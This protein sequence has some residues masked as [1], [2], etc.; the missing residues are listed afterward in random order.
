MKSV[1]IT[2]RV[3][4]PLSLCSRVWQHAQRS[5]RAASSMAEERS[6]FYRTVWEA[7]AAAVGATVTHMDGSL[8]EICCGELRLRVRDNVTSLD[9]PVTLEMAGKKPL[10]YRMLAE[11]QIPV[12]RHCVC[13]RDDVETAR[14][15]VAAAG[16]PCVI[17]PAYASSAGVGITTGV[18]DGQLLPLT[19]AWAGASSRDI[20]VEEQIGGE[21]Y[22]LLYLDGELVDA[23]L[24]RPPMVH[25]DGHST[26]RQLIAAEN[27]D[28]A[29]MGA[30]AAQSLIRV[31]H[32]LKFTLGRQGYHV[33][34]ILSP[35][36]VVP[37]KTVVND[38]RREENEAAS[39]RICPSIVEAGSAAAEALGV[40][41][42]GV[43]VITNDPGVPLSE[44]GA[45]VLEVNT[46]PGYYYHYMRK[47]G[48]AAVA[49]TI[50]QRL[51]GQSPSAP[52]DRAGGALD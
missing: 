35:G 47:G 9:D 25:G 13:R 10:V 17:K 12:P 28:R 16:G 30:E 48:G 41:L 42:A 51:T 31:D 24:R 40:R 37:V 23:V 52:S 33:G 8:L 43:D 36:A 11:R 14:R 3:V 34:S 6:L 45:V 50:L 19:M 15:F 2:R 49:V 4:E 38:N 26:I 21:N 44:S 20:V 1:L 27:A 7:A 46:T 18:M 22:R 39:N 29:R 5:T 32:D